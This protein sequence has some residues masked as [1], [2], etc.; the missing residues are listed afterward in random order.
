MFN[1][2]KLRQKKNQYEHELCFFFYIKNFLNIQKS[3][4]ACTSVNGKKIAKI[5]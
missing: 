2:T 3:R 4:H 1:E 5:K